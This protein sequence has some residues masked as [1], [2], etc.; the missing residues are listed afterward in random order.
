MKTLTPI[1]L[2]LAIAG[3]VLI[4]NSAYVVDET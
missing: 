4:A 3:V 2:I 1:L